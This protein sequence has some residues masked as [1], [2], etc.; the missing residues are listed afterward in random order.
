L[1]GQRPP[2]IS[3]CTRSITM[4]DGVF[5]SDLIVVLTVSTAPSM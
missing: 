3:G 1:I 4:D 2:S 5:G